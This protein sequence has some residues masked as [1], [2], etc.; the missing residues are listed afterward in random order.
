MADHKLIDALFD[1]TVGGLSESMT[2]FKKRNEAISS[3][4][5]N[6]ETPGYRAVD[7]D[8]GRELQQAFQMQE[9]GNLKQTN[10]RH[11]DLET[12]S[13]ARLVADYSG[14]TKNDG[15]NV[16]LDIQMGKMVYNAGKF[17]SGAALVRKKLQMMRMAIRMAMR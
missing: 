1:R 4:V 11:L 17:G 13:Q 15:N 12:D 5:A 10:S 16:D 14:P 7:V 6:A 3:N 8:F 9:G 2:L